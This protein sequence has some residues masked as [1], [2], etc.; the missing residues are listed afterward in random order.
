MF[1]HLQR[2]DDTALN[3]AQAKYIKAVSE[4]KRIIQMNMDGKDVS[5][6]QLEGFSNTLGSLDPNHV[7]EAAVEQMTEEIIAPQCEDDRA[8]FAVTSCEKVTFLFRAKQ[9]LFGWF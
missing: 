6:R 1:K 7:V 3:A 9:F 5:S 4:A 2:P 8:S